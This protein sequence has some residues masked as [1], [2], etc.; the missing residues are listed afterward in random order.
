MIR[1]GSVAMSLCLVL[2]GHLHRFLGVS[3][4]LC[5]V[6]Q[7]SALVITYRTVL[8][9]VVLVLLEA[10]WLCSGV[11]ALRTHYCCSFLD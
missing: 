1:R 2:S 7:A 10:A 9:V 5:K 4:I 8:R 3:G 6:L 11:K